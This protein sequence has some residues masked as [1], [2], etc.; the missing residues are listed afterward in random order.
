MAN[1]T[2]W[3]PVALDFL[4][5]LLPRHDPSMVHL[6]FDESGRED[7]QPAAFDDQELEQAWRDHGNDPRID[8]WAPE[9]QMHWLMRQ[10]LVERHYYVCIPLRVI[11][12]LGDLDL[13]LSEHG[14]WGSKT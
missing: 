5:K 14:C 11:H 7:Y 12:Q 2:P 3:R 6:L 4:D 1:S 13:F 10:P 9:A 8:H